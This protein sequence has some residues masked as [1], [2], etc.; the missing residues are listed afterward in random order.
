MTVCPACGQQN[1]DGFRF[2]GACASPLSTDG[3]PARE[4]RKTV[5]V[6][7]CDMAGS[8]QFADSSDPERVR[9]RM[10]R[11]H[12]LARRVLESRGA[13]IEKFIG[14]AVMAVFGVPVLYEDDALR[15]VRAVCELRDELA[16]AGIP[17]RI[18]VNT[19]EVVA[20]GGE[21][22]VTGDAVN[23]A[24]RLEQAAPVGEVWIGATTYRMT[25]DAVHAEPVDGVHAKGKPAPLAAYRLVTVSADAQAIP[26]RADSTLV[27]RGLE[28][29]MLSEAFERAVSEHRCHLFTV[30]GAPGV[31]KSRLV[32]ELAGGAAAG[33][34]VLVGQCL[35]YGEGITFWPVAEMLRT[36]AGIGE[37][38]DR[39]AAR[40][41]LERLVSDDE[42]GLLVAERVARAIGRG[43]TPAAEE[44]VFWALRRTFEIVARR[45][46]T[47]LV[48]ED[49]HWAD[50][51]LLE[52]IE[53]VADWTRGCALLILCTARPDLLDV[54]PEWAGGKPNATT[55]MLERLPAEECARLLEDLAGD[56]LSGEQRERVVTAS[57]GNPLFVEQML[58]MLTE[59]ER[60]GS[61]VPLTIQA[62]L[63]A[64]LDRLD[65]EERRVME[66]ASVEGRVFHQ[67][68]L[69]ALSS[70]AARPALAAHLQRLMRR[71]LI[72]PDRSLFEGDS[73]YRFQHVL[74]RDAAYAS[75]PKRA[76]AELHERFAEWLQE[77]VAHR[78]DEYREILAYHVE[79]AYLLLADVAPEDAHLEL[80]R[81]R[82]IDALVVAARQ[83][84][85]RG[86]DR[87]AFSIYS[88]AAS[89]P[90]AANAEALDLLIEALRVGWFAASPEE[91]LGISGRARDLASRLGDESR[92]LHARVLTL[93]AELM[94]DTGFS[95]SDA[96]ALAERAAARFEAEGE[97]LRLFDALHAIATAYHH[98]GHWSPMNEAL[99]RAAVIARELGDD[100]REQ[101]TDS[102]RLGA[103]YWGDS[104][105]TLGLNL[106]T[107]LL[108]RWPASPAMRSRVLC[109]QARF[110]AML[111]R[112]EEAHRDLADWLRSA[113]ALGDRYSLN[114][115][116][117]TTATIADME[118]DLDTALSEVS[119]SI[120]RLEAEGQRGLVATLYGLQGIF[121]ARAGRWDEAAESARRAHE[122]SHPD[123]LDSE[124]LWRWAQAPVMSH[125]GDAEGGL[126]LLREAI[127]I[128]DRTDETMFQANARMALGDMLESHGD[129]AGAGA[130]MREALELYRAKEIVPN[131]ARA[132]ERLVALD[133]A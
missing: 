42:D 129:T 23:V 105:A 26:R 30:M 12:D 20:G 83:A 114:S 25:R 121:Q 19:G 78:V 50:P 88:R 73:A 48:F 97:P 107:H 5:T 86:D 95:T 53:H 47:V 91:L 68:A 101:D 3:A 37:R 84:H 2:C 9:A 27:G 67:S 46:P 18:G 56:S 108:E 128:I 118:G 64:R 75:L 69:A 65:G 132:Q 126:A 82:A 24:A 28:L 17:A 103:Y 59:D 49:I 104:P 120:G 76:R 117:F 100:W 6:V 11:Y 22:L 124:A 35:P 85:E 72:D 14:D 70:D 33:A 87:S 31:G 115:R 38:D 66:S 16:A 116:A 99:M 52:L 15:A 111:G 123:D 94:A 81:Q 7:F 92:A 39:A 131:I 8:T 125:W 51:T 96:H 89:L 1:P 58:A 45:R 130:A 29:S 10:G 127:A 133:G 122:Q 44:E 79:Q 43:G 98:E 61:D 90:Q 13:T 110:L 113:E 74:I 54:R 57:E 80:L 34:N 106:C 93:D 55:I 62:L 21:A 102:A 109:F 40:T 77:R 60:G 63:A 36:A 32:A 4:V 41:T 112:S 71:E 119:W